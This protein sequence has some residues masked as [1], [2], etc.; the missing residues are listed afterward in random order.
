[1]THILLDPEVPFFGLY[2]PQVIHLYQEQALLGVRRS[3]LNIAVPMQ[4]FHR[5]WA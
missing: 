1:M 3:H 2:Q 4:L 5:E